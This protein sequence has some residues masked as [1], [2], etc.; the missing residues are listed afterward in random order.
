MENKKG[1]LS[2]DLVKGVVLSLLVITI[3]SV[4]VIMILPLL[5]DTTDSLDK[6]TG[7]TVNETLTS[8]EEAGEALTIGAYRLPSC[9]VTECVNV[10]AGITV[11][12]ANY[13][14]TGCRVA[15]SGAEDD[16]GFNNSNWNCDY[17]WSY[18]SPDNTNIVSNVTTGAASFFNSSG[19]IFS[20]LVAI[21]IISAIGIIVVI[22][23]RFGGGGNSN[24]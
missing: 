2:L 20:I 10:T 11:P 1:Q 12:A 21:V 13:T 15:F 17:T 9:T 7:N 23:G 16:Q 24:L 8:V 3:L 22:V 18:T 19:T 5:R 6:I 14:A 4:S